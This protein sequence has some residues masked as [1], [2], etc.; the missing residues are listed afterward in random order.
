MTKSEHPWRRS[1]AAQV[2]QRGL[3]T[4]E[5]A[6]AYLRVST[7]TV[8]NWAAAG[9][10]TRYPWTAR[11]SRYRKSDLDKILTYAQKRDLPVTYRLIRDYRNS[12]GV[13]DGRST[14]KK[15]GE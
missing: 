4:Q 5:Q 10:L 9:L 14:E 6:A 8:V 15:E 1:G 7:R 12:L 11:Y 13:P 2:R 3:L